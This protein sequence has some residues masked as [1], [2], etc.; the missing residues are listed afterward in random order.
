MPIV[1]RHILITFLVYALFS[2]AVLAQPKVT[3]D[4]VGVDSILETNIR[5]FLSIEQQKDS[6]LLTP[7]QLRR[8]HRKANREI[9]A[10]LEPYGY[11][12]PQIETNLVDEGQDRW[13]ATY[14][15]V[16]GAP[17]VIES[18]EFT[19]E[20]DALGDPA[21][22]TLIKSDKPQV[23]MTFS[24]LEYESFKSSLGQLATER[25]YFAANFVRHRVEID[26]VTNV[27][28]IYL[29]YDSGPRYRFGELRLD[30]ETID[31]EL[32]RRYATFKPGDPYSLDLLLEF[33]QALN[34]TRY[35]QS[36]EVAPDSTIADS[37]EIPIRVKLAPRNR[38]HY[39]LGLGYGTDTGARAKFGW[40]VPLINPSGHHFDSEIGVSEIGHKIFG[41]YRIP[42]LNPRTDQLVFS[43]GEE[44]EEF[45]TGTSTKRSLGVSLNHGRGKWRE[46]LS[47]EYQDEDFTIDNED[48]NS[49]L[50]LPGVSWNRIW[51]R[52]FIN[53]LDG[54]RFD[55]A[56]RGADTDLAS[57]T[58]FMQY[59]FK[60]KFITPLG[61]RDRIIL[62]GSAAT[63]ETDDFEDIPS[64]IRY[65]AGGA[66][67]VRG[68]AYQSLG[69]TDDDGD[70]IGAQR[71]LVGS[72]E[73]EHYFNDRWGMA[74]FFDAGN[75]IDK[76]DDDLEQGAGFGL[77]WKSV[78]GPVRI[79]LANAI[80]DD[81]DWR[82][83][84]NIGP[85]L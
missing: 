61:R 33:Q 5:L 67:S 53:V 64:S 29:D 65:Y 18:F 7:A 37:N 45:E 62:R 24:H 74:L 79:D 27:A 1:T 15:I 59:G 38:H 55:F 4:I 31:D 19:L 35:F 77:R 50:L 9:T 10:A 43:A 39:K 13:R 54:V 60:L 8:L 85:D 17:V 26:R 75:A 46:T 76:F 42:V 20:G 34:N 57:D 41:N 56:V 49:I 14:H 12:Q 32:L 2:T 71:L 25:G 70:A 78:V 30:Q 6:E 11:Y 84:I 3:I 22:D 58:D 68:Y 80:S 69:P 63:I 72:I 40:Q 16:P 51:G 28:Y 44:E 81:E 83:H 82:L 48:K 66:S 36:V 21:F 73:Y 23:G 47:L 52:E